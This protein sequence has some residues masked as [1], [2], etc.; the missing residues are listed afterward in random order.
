M[1]PLLVTKYGTQKMVGD[2]RRNPPFTLLIKFDM[3]TSDAN[4]PIFKSVNYNLGL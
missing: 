1:I 4:M 3:I 2:P